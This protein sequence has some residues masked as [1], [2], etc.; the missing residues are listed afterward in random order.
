MSGPVFTGTAQLL[1]GNDSAIDNASCAPAC[2]ARQHNTNQAPTPPG[3]PSANPLA[4]ARYSPGLR[5]QPTSGTPRPCGSSPL[6]IVTTRDT[7]RATTPSAL[8][9]GL[10]VNSS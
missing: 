9:K 6:A 2:I 10:S 3:V 7:A 5:I 1:P 4:A 8:P